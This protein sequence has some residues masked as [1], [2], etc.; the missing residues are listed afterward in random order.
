[1]AER[2]QQLLSTIDKQVNV[3]NTA[4]HTLE[5]KQQSPDPQKLKKLENLSIDTD[6]VETGLAALQ[7]LDE[8]A[9]ESAGIG[10]S[11]IPDDVQSIMEEL[12]GKTAAPAAPASPAPAQLKPRLLR[13]ARKR[14]RRLH[15]RSSA[16]PSRRRGNPWR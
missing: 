8:E 9:N 10:A 11:D 5:L 6:D 2:R 14:N 16:G 7:Q 15:Q 1:M 12:R 4:I 13:K 3:I